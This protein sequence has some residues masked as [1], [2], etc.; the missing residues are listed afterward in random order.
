MGAGVFAA[1]DGAFGKQRQAADGGGAAGGYGGV[2]QDLVEKGQIDGI[3]VRVEGHRGDVDGGIDQLRR[4]HLRHP[5][6]IQ[7]RLGFPGQIDPQ[8]LDAV[9]IPAGIGNLLGMDGKGAAQL[10]RPAPQGVM[11]AFTHGNTS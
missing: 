6:S 8:I 2:R 11:T 5:R 9:L 4:A 1:E 7:H 10:L 3:V